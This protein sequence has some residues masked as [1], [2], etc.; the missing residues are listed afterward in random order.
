M[1]IVSLEVCPRLFGLRQVTRLLLALLIDR[2]G[3]L[4]VA[5][6]ERLVQLAPGA[7]IVSL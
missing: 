7:T 4:R 6:R 3:A 2:L 5:V 1:T